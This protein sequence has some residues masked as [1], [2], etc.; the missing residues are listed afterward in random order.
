[1][2]EQSPDRTLWQYFSR[3][4]GHSAD[5]NDCY[6]GAV[7]FDGEVFTVAR[8]ALAE[9]L[10]LTIAHAGNGAEREAGIPITVEQRGPVPELHGGEL[11]LTS[12][13]HLGEDWAAWEE[14]LSGVTGAGASALIIGLGAGAVFETLPAQVLQLAEGHDLPLLVA[15]FA[16]FGRIAHSITALHSHAL[17][18]AL[19]RPLDLQ[20]E[21]TAIVARGGS[22][23]DLLD[24]WQQRTAEPVAVF[25][26]LG[27]ALGRSSAF[28]SGLLGSLGERLASHEAPRLGE[29]FR[30]SSTTLES[31][32]EAGA[33]AAQQPLEISPFAGNDT[34]RGYC[35]RIPTG[36][37]TAELAA[38]ALRSLLALEFERL[39]FLDEPARRKRADG[40]ARLLTLTEEGSARAFLRSFGIDSG[41]LRGVA[42]EARNET[43]AEVLVDDLALVLA[44]PFIRH[45]HRIVECLAT[46]EPRQALADYGLDVPTGIGTP[47]APERSARSIRQAALALETSRRV[48]APIE[49]VDGA[50]HEFLIR[51][52]PSEYLELFSAAALA[53]IEHSR[54]GESL[55]LTLHTWLLERRSIEATAERMGVHRHTVRNRIQRIAQLT[56]HDLDG[57]D[58]QTEMWL[59]LK[60]RGF[61][62]DANGYPPRP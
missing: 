31:L 51:A 20:M 4:H 11:V 14:F 12:G 2:T 28:P 44:A 27:R 7:N 35:A 21:I 23:G 37:P 16:D 13:L 40:F 62:D 34:V 50:S 15:E 3:H 56:G 53:P 59:A 57:I 29:Q 30:L 1:M 25:D 8:L 47:G 17:R 43:H 33:A 38:P 22:F 39:W 32:A 18:E 24:G 6:D 9:G 46:V 60:A 52:A 49:Y 36:R 10:G 5:R 48:G 45:R 19:R 55:L 41:A 26:R 54:G 61:R 42:I 58:A